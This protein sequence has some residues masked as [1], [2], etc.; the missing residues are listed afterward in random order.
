MTHTRESLVKRADE[1]S[2]SGRLNIGK[3]IEKALDS[4]QPFD[5]AVAVRDLVELRER[6]G[7]RIPE[8]GFLSTVDELNDML[9]D[10]ANFAQDGCNCR[11]SSI[12]AH[13]G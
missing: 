2:D 5:L 10:L 7:R 11:K 8:R 1:L 9:D 3:H 13:T 4:C 6:Y 12:S